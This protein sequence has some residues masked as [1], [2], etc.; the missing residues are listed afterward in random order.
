[1]ATEVVGRDEVG[2]VAF[3]LRVKAGA[4]FLTAATGAFA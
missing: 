3:E 4:L 1:M 2:K